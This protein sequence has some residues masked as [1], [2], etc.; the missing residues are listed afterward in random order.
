[1]AHRLLKICVTSLQ[2]PFISRVLNSGT[3]CG[4]LQCK[5]GYLQFLNPPVHFRNAT[6]FNRYPADRLWKSATNVSNAGKKRGRAKSRRMIKNL[7]R[8]Q[9]IGVG[10]VN[11]VWPGLNAP[12]VR[13][14]ELVQQQQLPENPEREKQIFKLRDSMQRKRK[15]KLHPLERGWS[16]RKPGGRRMGPP[17][18]IGD[19]KFEG[20]DSVILEYKLVTVMT[21]NMGRKRRVSCMVL[22]GNK[23][24]LA[25]VSVAKAPEGKAALRIAKNRA[26]MKLMFINRCNEHTVYHD[27]FCQFGKTKI[28]VTKKSEGYGLRCHRAIKSC[29]EL[30]GIKDLHAKVEGSHNL[31]HIIKAFFIGLLQQK[32]HEQLAEEK[33]LHLVEFRDENDIFP[34]VV[35]SPTQVRKS[36]EIQ[37]DEIMDFTQYVLGGKVILRKKKHPPFFHSYLSWTIRKRKTAWLRNKDEVRT[38]LYAEHGELRSFYTDKYPEAKPSLWNKNLKAKEEAEFE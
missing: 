26:A 31:Q 36:E 27:F 30:I 28:Y 38:R 35:A 16:G 21:G 25:G 13:G 7:N 23:N 11:I 12:A 5:P 15:V 37:P 6:F 33:K 18:P 1:M 19:E 14:R 20:F 22:T 29:C 17:D 24:G 34:T 8:G 9:V 10:K 4:T 2:T 32:T 3:S